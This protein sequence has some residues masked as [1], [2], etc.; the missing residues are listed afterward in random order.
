MPQD[1]KFNARAR[2]PKRITASVYLEVVS[3]PQI[4][5]KSKTQLDEKAVHIQ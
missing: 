5:L 1:T 3:K 2:C 4:A